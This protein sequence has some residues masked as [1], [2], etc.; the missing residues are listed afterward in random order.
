MSQ[1]TKDWCGL[2]R[3]D[4]AE[5]SGFLHN[6]KN[7][8]DEAR[9]MLKKVQAAAQDYADDN[10]LKGQAIKTSQTYFEQ[11][12]S[13]ICKSLFEALN[14]SED[15][16]EQSICDFKDQVDAS[17]NARIDAELLQEAMHRLAEIK[18]KQ[19]DLLQK[20]AA[21]TGTLYEGR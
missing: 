14:E 1:D 4:I 12:Y 18:R 17:P 21:S 11:T 19:E 13:V 6:L 8:N 2:S 7:S 9:F 15:R 20:M 16:L 5:L 10:S 3:I